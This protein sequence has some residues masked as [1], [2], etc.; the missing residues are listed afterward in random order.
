MFEIIFCIQEFDSLLHENLI[1]NINC[2]RIYLLCI[3]VSRH[4]ML[5]SVKIQLFL[6]NKYENL[7]FIRSHIA[8]FHVRLLLI[9]KVKLGVISL[10]HRYILVFFIYLAILYYINS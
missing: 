9:I 3:E 1:I 10:I 8:D 2:A 6:I 5:I 4:C 7:Y